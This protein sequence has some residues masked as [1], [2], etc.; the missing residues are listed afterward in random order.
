MLPAE[1]GSYTSVLAYMH[2]CLHV[3][4]ACC[5]STHMLC[6]CNACRQLH[7]VCVCIHVYVD[8][9][10]WLLLETQTAPPSALFLYC[11]IRSLTTKI[12]SVSYHV[13]PKCH[14]SFAVLPKY[15]HVVVSSGYMTL[16]ITI[17]QKMYKLWVFIGFLHFHDVGD[18]VSSGYRLLH[19]PPSCR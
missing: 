18:V 9:C 1:G 16:P 11:P 2:S 19:C 10:A 15:G 8:V 6:Q 13:T 7:V 4:R 14:S 17:I 12:W 5:M 3:C